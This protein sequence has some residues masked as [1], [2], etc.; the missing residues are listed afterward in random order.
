[1]GHGR[2]LTVILAAA[3]AAIYMLVLVATG[4]LTRADATTVLQLRK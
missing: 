2:V 1:M 4:E 3:V